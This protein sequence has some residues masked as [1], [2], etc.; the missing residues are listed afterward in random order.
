MSRSAAAT[1]TSSPMTKTRTLLRV[2]SGLMPRKRITYSTRWSGSSSSRTTSPSVTKSVPF[3]FMS[4]LCRSINPEPRHESL[5]LLFSRQHK[6]GRQGYQL[7]YADTTSS[8]Q[9]RDCCRQH[10]SSTL[11]VRDFRFRSRLRLH[12]DARG[13]RVVHECVEWVKEQ[14]RPPHK[15]DGC[16]DGSKPTTIH[17]IDFSFDISV[18]L[19][20]QN[21]SR[22]LISIC[23]DATS[24]PHM[25]HACGKE[26][27]LRGA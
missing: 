1:L 18:S 9:W 5:R 22:D 17:R 23:D 14:V 2:A 7:F 21:L 12:L 10:W 11:R 20:P 16:S 24:H 19:V 15:P 25:L 13:R 6:L 4:I 27:Q 8:G 3:D 26:M